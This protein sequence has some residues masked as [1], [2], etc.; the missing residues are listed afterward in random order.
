MAGTDHQSLVSR[1][2]VGIVGRISQSSR[3]LAIG[4]AECIPAICFAGLMLLV[5]VPQVLA[6]VLAEPAPLPQH[7]SARQSQSVAKAPANVSSTWGRT[8]VDA[9]GQ[10]SQAPGAGQV[11]IVVKPLELSRFEPE[12]FADWGHES[13]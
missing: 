10:A 6:E 12:A 7:A 11:A 9:K 4:L 13:P 3:P 1:A 8:A 2:G 5:A